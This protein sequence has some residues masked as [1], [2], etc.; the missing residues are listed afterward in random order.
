M[1]IYG[2]ELTIADGDYYYRFRTRFQVEYTVRFLRNE[3]EGYLQEY[4]SLLH[5]TFSFAFEKNAQVRTPKDESVFKTL[6]AIVGNFYE[7]VGEEVILLYICDTTDRREDE[8]KVLFSRWQQQS[9]LRQSHLHELATVMSEKGDM[10]FH[11][12][13][14]FSKSHRLADAVLKDFRALLVA[15]AK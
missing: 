4:P 5:H 9:Q 6:D 2:Y 8:R 13:L 15:W 11:L 7:V 10:G 3:Y 12:G 14:I 1:S